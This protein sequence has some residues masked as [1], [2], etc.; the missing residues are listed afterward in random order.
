MPT[1][2]SGRG[3]GAGRT[4]GPADGGRRELTAAGRSARGDTPPGI[5]T[6]VTPGAAWP[7]PGPAGVGWSSATVVGR[8]RRR[9]RAGRAAG[10][11]GRPTGPAEGDRRRWPRWPDAHLD[12]VRAGGPAPRTGA[13]APPAPPARRPV[14]GPPGR[15]PSRP[16]AACRGPRPA[17]SAGSGR[18]AIRRRRTGRPGARRRRGQPL[19]RGAVG[20]L[21]PGCHRP[22]RAPGVRSAGAPDRGRRLATSTRRPWPSPGWPPGSPSSGSSPVTCVSTRTPPTGKPDSW[23]RSSSPG[24]TEEPRGPGP[25]PADGGRLAG[26]GQQLRSALLRRALADLLGG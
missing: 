26:L 8:R 22:L 19:A 11:H 15:R 6:R 13:T 5:E 14:A 20:G 3:A 25:C 23:S 4:A 7:G 17:G 24:Q 12:A 16:V 18:T 9:C 10:T 1:N 21:R 2:Q